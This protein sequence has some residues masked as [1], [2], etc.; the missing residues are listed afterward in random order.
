MAEWSH[1]LVYDPAT[2]PMSGSW[3]PTGG[4]T[5]NAFALTVLP[6]ALPAR[7]VHVRAPRR[8]RR[9][10][11]RYGLA[12]NRIRGYYKQLAGDQAN[13]FLLSGHDDGRGVR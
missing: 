6:N 5:F 8:V 1:N 12:I 2:L 7:R 10:G 9:R 13:L 11:L 4:D 3:R